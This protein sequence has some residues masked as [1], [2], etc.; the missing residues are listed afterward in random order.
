M[1][2]VDAHH[3]KRRARIAL[4]VAGLVAL[5][6]CGGSPRAPGTIVI[7]SGTDLEGMQPFTTTQ[8]LARQVQRHLVL[9]P[10]VALDSTLAIVPRAATGWRWSPDGR[11]LTLALD[12]TLRW[13]DGT[14]FTGADAVVTLRLA[15]DSAIGWARRRELAGL[16][17]VVAPT[18]DSLVLTFETPPGD[19]PPVLA[20]L[21]L[22]PAHRAARWTADSV[23]TGA[24]AVAPIGLGPYRVEAREPGRRWVLRRVPRFP[25]RLG[26]PGASERIVIAVVDEATTKVAGLVSGAVDLAGINPAT[27]ALVARDPTLRLVTYPTLYTNWLVFTAARPPFDDERVR[28]AVALSLDRRRIVDA[29][30]GGYASPSAAWTADRARDTTAADTARADALLDA[31]GWRRGAD[32]VRVRGGTRFEVTLLCA[33]TA[34]NAVEQL[35]QGDLRA[36]GIVVRIATREAGALL[37]EARAPG[38][39][40]ALLVTGVPGDA[41][42]GQL[43]ALFDPAAAGGA[44]DFGQA[45]PASVGAALAAARRAGDAATRAAAWGAVF[46]ALDAELP[47]VPVYHARGVQGAT[48]RLRGVAIDLRGELATAARWTLDPT[49][50]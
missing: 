22:V 10:L 1:M 8:N 11:T 6:G 20:E 46:G 9:M 16:R 18:A 48:R 38:R 21:P 3:A 45:R 15:T 33:A 26:G 34:D 36:R 27:A 41:A 43:S 4:A 35:I 2:P 24:F 50:P 23:R 49:T 19:V 12:T 28:R 44:L 17:R 29:G 30:V 42:R 25:A 7:A 37:V 39:T 31:A 14:P 13:H 47:A 5:A 32:G 40:H